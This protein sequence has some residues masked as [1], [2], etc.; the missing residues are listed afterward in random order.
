MD[1][2]CP[3]SR[4]H[5]E[6]PHAQAQH[7]FLPNLEV[8]VQIQQADDISWLKKGNLFWNLSFTY[9]WYFC[10]WQTD[11]NIYLSRDYLYWKLGIGF[12]SLSTLQAYQLFEQKERY[13]S[14]QS[15]VLRILQF[16]FRE[17]FGFID[18]VG[19]IRLNFYI[20]QRGGWFFFLL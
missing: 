14:I 1:A 12:L 5:L 7:H 11:K 17:T 2:L 16:I 19:W 15:W 6:G 4:A 18:R 8:T 20:R 3:N 10:D 13:F 9:L